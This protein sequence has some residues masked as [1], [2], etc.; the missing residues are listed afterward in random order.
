[1]NTSEP[2]PQAIISPFVGHYFKI[3]NKLTGDALGPFSWQELI[4]LA[5]SG[6]LHLESRIADVNTPERWLKV[7][8]T[9]LVFELPLSVEDHRYDPVI[10][11]P[12]K[13]SQRSRDYLILL[14]LGNFFILIMNFGIA[15]NAVSLMFI[16]AL[17][18]IY[19]LALAW[20]LF[21]IMRPY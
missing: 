20:I 2:K 15:L 21:G 5:R 9:P 18:V 16:L 3:H 11:K 17:F 7:A 8:E 10:K 12:F 19:N 14:V 4:D 13:L 6:N 1:M